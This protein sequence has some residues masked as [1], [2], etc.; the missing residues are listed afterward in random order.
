MQDRQKKY[1]INNRTLLR[2]VKEHMKGRTAAE[3]HNKYL[4][5][6]YNTLSDENNSLKRKAYA[7]SN[8]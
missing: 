7:K 5:E 8:L 3:K 1:E 4:Q 6:L 2:K